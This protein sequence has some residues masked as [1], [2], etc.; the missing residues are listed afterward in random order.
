MNASNV[1]ERLN[2]S[3]VLDYTDCDDTDATE[4]PTVFWYADADGDGFGDA[5]MLWFVSAC[6]Y[7]C[8]GQ[9]RL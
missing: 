9:Y 8:L 6:T 7:R 5:L 1:C 2:P 3:D 4:N